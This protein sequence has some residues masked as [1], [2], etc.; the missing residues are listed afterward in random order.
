MATGMH[1]TQKGRCV[2]C[3]AEISVPDFYENGVTIPCPTCSLDHRVQKDEQGKLKRLVVADVTPLKEQLEQNRRLVSDTEREYASAR[4]SLGIG[5]NGLGLGL[6]YVVAQVG[7]EEKTID[8]PLLMTAAAIAVV[9]GVLLEG[10]NYMFLA[11]RHT[12][13]R[14]S[15]Q[16][17][18]ARAE[19]RRL[20]QIVRDAIRASRV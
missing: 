12:L 14:L 19:N 16:L 8:T 2:S 9:T 4:A 13:G 20:E 5:A 10:A 17:D 3:R 18:E 7:W 6:L 11:K 15:Q 1:K